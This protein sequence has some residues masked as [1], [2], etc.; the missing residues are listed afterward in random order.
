MTPASAAGAQPPRPTRREV[1]RVQL[2]RALGLAALVV[3]LAA[4]VV[5]LGARIPAERTLT[6]A[7]DAAA[8][9]QRRLD[10]ARAATEAAVEERNA[11]AAGAARAQQERDRA[12][13]AL[14]AEVE[15]IRAADLQGRLAAADEIVRLSLE[16]A[17][18]FVSMNAAALADDAVTYNRLAAQSN[19]FV[20]RVNALW[21]DLLDDQPGITTPSPIV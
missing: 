18:R 21:A 20:Q 12:G 7:E 19:T 10:E 1:R 4:L 6:E 8:Q 16:Q 9:A 11:A 15:G 3:G 2:L 13:S 5:A 17:D 14:T